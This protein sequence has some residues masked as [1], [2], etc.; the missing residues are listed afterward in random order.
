LTKWRRFW[1]RHLV[2]A[3]EAARE[4]GNKRITLGKGDF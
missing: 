1:N 2:V 3:F 4:A